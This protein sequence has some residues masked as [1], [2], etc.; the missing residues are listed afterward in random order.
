MKN[1]TKPVGGTDYPTTFQE[2][3]KWFA[4][5]SACLEYIEKL[6]WPNGFT[7]PSCGFHP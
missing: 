1:S 2:F 7:C 5:E 4:D 3:D 6:R